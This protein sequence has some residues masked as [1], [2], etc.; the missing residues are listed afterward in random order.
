MMYKIKFFH[1]SDPECSFHAE[2]KDWTLYG[3]VHINI[4]IALAESDSSRAKNFSFG[5]KK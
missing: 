4:E 5:S 2:K 1:Y 3:E